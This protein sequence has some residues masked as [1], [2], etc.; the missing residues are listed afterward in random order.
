MTRTF[1]D[2]EATRSRVPLMIGL[3]SPSGAGKTVS[4]LRVA[5][6]IQRVV[7]GDIMLADTESR[8]ALHY[9]DKF[10]FR[11]IDFKPPFSSLDY[12]ELAEHAVKRGAR[13]VIFDSM[14]PEHDHMLDM[15]TAETQRLAKLWECKESKAQMAAWAKPKAERR[16][17]IQGL[18]QLPISAIFCFRAKEK[19]KVVP[20]KDPQQLG[21]M[22]IAG[23]EFIFEMTINFLLLPRANGVPT[24]SSDEIGERAMMKLPLQFEGIFSKPEQLSEAHGEKMALWAEGDDRAE[25]RTLHADIEAAPTME[26]LAGLSERM[27]KTKA[28]WT[29]SEFGRLAQAGKARKAALGGGA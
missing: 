11:H 14:S 27:T 2:T 17:M 21:Y 7:G 24:W 19:L 26:A 6:G 25:F 28:S 9:A 15:H 20:G 12:L 22:A 3:V 18:L 1:E 23:E 13:V 4:A 16:K 10:K 5:T 29:A 8:R